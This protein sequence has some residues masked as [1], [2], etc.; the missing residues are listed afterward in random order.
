MKTTLLVLFAAS[1]MTLLSGCIV[2]PPR[3]NGYYEAP[4]YER[5]NYDRDWRRDGR[6]DRRGRY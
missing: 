4:R 2:V 6:D 3:H 5:G 1:T